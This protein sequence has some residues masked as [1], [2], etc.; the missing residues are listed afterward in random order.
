MNAILFFTILSLVSP[1]F[2]EEALQVKKHEKRGIFGLGYGGYYGGGGGIGGLGG[3]GHGGYA[4]NSAGYSLGHNYG[5]APLVSHGYNSAPIPLSHG[6][7]APPTYS[8]SYLDH[9]GIA[10][11]HGFGGG[12][13][14]KL[15]VIGNYG[16]T[17]IKGS[18]VSKMRESLTNTSQVLEQIRHR[19]TLLQMHKRGPYKK[20]KKSKNPLNGKPF[21]KGIVLKTVIKKPKKP[22][23]ANR[24]CVIVKLTTGREMTAYVPELIE[25][26]TDLRYCSP[27]PDQVTSEDTHSTEPILDLSI[28]K[29]HVSPTSNKNDVPNEINTIKKLSTI[30]E[31]NVKACKRKYN[32]SPVER[33]YSM[34]TPPSESESPKEHKFLDN[35]LNGLTFNNNI[36]K[37]P[38]LTINVP[39]PIMPTMLP[40]L[41]M[42]EEKDKTNINNQLLTTTTT[43]TTT[44]IGTNLISQENQKKIPRPFKAYPAGFPISETDLIFNSQSCGEPFADFRE[45]M[46]V[47]VRR[48]SEPSNPKMRRTNK[49]ASSSALPTSTTA[50]E[51]D[52]AYRERRK[53]N[54]EAAKRS[55]DARRAKEDEIAIRAA[56]LEKENLRLKYEIIALRNENAGL[57][58]LLYPS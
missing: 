47:T 50:E 11:G 43:T 52:A 35:P 41:F 20:T 46:L 7:S 12:H 31:G 10:L 9:S 1:I 4:G 55:R 25:Q 16:F 45:R 33:E 8:S 14:N 57:K 37:L 30:K 6:Y 29:N 13:V 18:L 19:T 21:A 49:T 38:N 3:Y 56:Y 39:V 51:K 32:D 17:G 5:A 27:Y 2:S 40:T 48:Q 26:P 24:K 58:N 53:K 23:S 54:N 42:E 22:N 34:F 44:T 36:E 15:H 28:K